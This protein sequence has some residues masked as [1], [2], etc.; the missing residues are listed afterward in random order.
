M[1]T[2]LASASR[3]LLAGTISS[4]ACGFA[5]HLA[6][7]GDGAFH[8]A[9]G[10]G[11]L[12]EGE[13]V[14]FLAAE[15]DLAEPVALGGVGVLQQVQNRQRELALAQVAA[16]RLAGLRLVAGEIEH[17]VVD[18]V[19]RAEAQAEDAQRADHLGRRF[20]DER[21]Q[22]ARRGEERRRSSSR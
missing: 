17:I 4:C 20:I 13:N 5:E 10:D 7:G 2:R 8:G 3:Y 6:P 16:E 22:F 1:V 15:D 21:A 12:G 9:G 11:L 14:V 18:L 19:G